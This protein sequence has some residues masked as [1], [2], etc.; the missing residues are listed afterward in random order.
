MIRQDRKKMVK[1]LD[2]LF[3]AYIRKRDGKCLKCLRTDTLQCCHLASRKNLAGR[4]N[5]KNAITLCYSCHI[6]WAHKEPIDFTN[7]VKKN[8]PAYYAEALKVKKTTVKDLDLG[9]LVLKYS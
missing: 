7:W 8:Y 3:S 2:T 6:F 5:D 4:W 1:K 9:A